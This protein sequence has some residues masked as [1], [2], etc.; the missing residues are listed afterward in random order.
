MPL[1]PRL[2][3]VLRTPTNRD[4]LT[5]ELHEAAALRAELDQLQ[6]AIASL[7]AELDA[8]GREAGELSFLLDEA[9]LMKAAL[10]RELG[11]ERLRSAIRR[12]LLADI[13]AE[14]PWRRRRAIDRSV[15]V[16]RFMAS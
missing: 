10:E 12:R 14:K 7:S 3:R 13:A 9:L 4:V 2:K 16:E 8:S 5:A 15:R 6:A 11:H 1:S